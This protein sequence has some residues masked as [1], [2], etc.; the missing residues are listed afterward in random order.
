MKIYYQM[1]TRNTSFIKMHRYLKA[2]GIKNNKFML[3][4]LDPD[5]AGSDPHDHNLNAYYKSKDL[6]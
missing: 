6:A 4:L 5:L 2:I 3:V 1:S